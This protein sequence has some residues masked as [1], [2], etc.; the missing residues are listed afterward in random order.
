M[1][2][3][4]SSPEIILSILETT[5]TLG[6][7][8]GELGAATIVGSAA[9]NLLMIS[10]VSILAVNDVKKINDLFVFTTTSIFSVWAYIWLYVCLVQSSAN[11]VTLT[12]AWLT[13]FF[14]VLLLI[15]S[16]GADR[17]NLRRQSRIEDEAKIKAEEI[18]LKRSHLRT[19]AR[20]RGDQGM[21][22]KIIIEC[23]QGIKNKYTQQIP[24]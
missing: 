8:A 14:F 6:E 24:E 13:L 2:L 22:E 16:Y 4:S 12:E 15:L 9:Y 11:E 18:K 10:A 5:S 1:A 17:F 21:G 23:A 3:G 19:I 7:P 20:L